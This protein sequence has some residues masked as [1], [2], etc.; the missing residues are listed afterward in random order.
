MK[1]EDEHYELIADHRRKRACQIFGIELILII[2]R[3]MTRSKAVI[4]MAD[5]NLQRE[6]ILPSKKGKAYN[7]KTDVMRRQGNKTDLTL[8]TVGAKLRIDEVI[9]Q[10]SGKSC[11]QMQRYIRLN[12]LTS[13]LFVF[14]GERKIGMRPAAEFSYSQEEE[15]RDLVDYISCDFSIQILFHQGSCQSHVQDRHH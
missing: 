14:V 7:M 13:E 10:E 4:E 5:S 11:N 6:H 2:V 15:M 1:K 8:S 9:A 12:E 3:E